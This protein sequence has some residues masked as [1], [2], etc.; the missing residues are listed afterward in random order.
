MFNKITPEKAGISSR[1]VA[2]FI[3]HLERRG[4]VTHG[5]L[6]MKGDDIF[7]EY[8]WEPFGPDFCHRM[9]SQTKSYT[10]IAIG[11]LEE[12][13]KVNLDDKMVDYF[14]EKT[15]K[16]IPQHVR[17]MTLR[18]MLTMTTTG[19][20][21]YWFTSDELDRTKLYLE[22]APGT[23]PSGTY[24]EYDSPG[25]QVL[26]SLVEKLSGK[27]LLDYLKE[28]LFNKMGTF[29]TAEILKTRNGDS[30]GDSALICTMRDMA[31]F[32]RL[33]TNGGV[34]QGERLMNEE[35]IRKATS[36]VVCNDATGFR[37]ALSHGYGYQIWK[38]EQDGFAFIGMGGQLT[39]CLPSKDLMLVITGD[40]QGYDA[41]KEIVINAF[42]DYIAD[43]A[44]E[45][46]PQ[47]DE[48]EKVLVEATKDLKLSVVCGN[49]VNP[50]CKE[51]NGKKF[52]CEENPM[53]ITEFFF[54]FSGDEVAFNYVNAQGEKE[55]KIGLGK[56]SFGKFPQLGY[57]NDFGGIRTTDGFM[58]DCA[59]SGA[60]R[61]E[62][63]FTFKVQVIDR[64]FGN[65]YCI[66]SFKD[67]YCVLKMVKSAEDFLNEY[68]GVA[69]AKAA[70]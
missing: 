30:W 37:S 35:Y 38:I 23:H 12:E 49:Y 59:A 51:I 26:S 56:N 44:G 29:K 27:S 4:V 17:D 24:W 50:F 43:D 31:S 34:W 67:N 65:F 18:E 1:N 69:V 39:L 20:P 7:A 58:Y 62:K 53:G 9:Y 48:A 57:S 10:S 6:L 8:Y 42:F 63:K 15:E 33:L 28:K 60:W 41:Y 52:I 16:Q 55:I 54:N 47:D 25:S 40:N 5:I 2:K 19:N 68:S 66:A 13:G 3:N 14:P 32:G 21:D 45:P 70:E 61:E 64:Y 36:A 11:L 46:L 22:T